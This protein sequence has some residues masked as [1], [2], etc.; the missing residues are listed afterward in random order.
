[1]L[2]RFLDTM[3][4]P[5]DSHLASRGNFHASKNGEGRSM[6][7]TEIATLRHPMAPDRFNS[8]SE[9]SDSSIVLPELNSVTEVNC[10]LEPENFTAEEF[11]DLLRKA[12]STPARKSGPKAK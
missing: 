7:C 6:D 10:S 1:M 2:G 9:P 8:I 12:I 11:D 4:Y 5:S 3:V